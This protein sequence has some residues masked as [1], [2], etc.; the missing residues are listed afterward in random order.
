MC[1]F[2]LGCMR[3]GSCLYV[4]ERKQCHVNE[5]SM[6]VLLTLT[7]GP[8]VLALLLVDSA[9]KS[10]ALYCCRDRVNGGHVDTSK[11]FYWRGS[12]KKGKGNHYKWTP[13][14]RRFTVIAL[15]L[16]A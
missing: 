9:P 5:K 15:V 13:L 4:T 3:V 8:V 2:V 12:R 10:V 6:K 14:L 11:V 16:A 1:V 7:C